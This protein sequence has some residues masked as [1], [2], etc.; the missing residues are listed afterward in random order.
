VRE[1][2]KGAGDRPGLSRERLVAAALE[3]VSAN[4]LDGL[5]MR[6]LADRLRVK[7]ASLYWHV[8]DRR[9]LLELLA[10]SILAGV[11]GVDDRAGWRSGV[12]AQS[13]A[14]RQVVSAQKDASRILLEVPDAVD[15]SPVLARMA[16]TLGAAGLGPAEAREVARMVMV[17]VIAVATT[18]ET[19]EAADVRGTSVAALAVDSGS[20]GVVVRRGE[21]LEGL[22]RVARDRAGAAPAVVRGETVIVR[23]LRGVGQ[24]EIELNGRRP[25]TFQVQG[26]TWNTTLELAGLDVRGIKLDSG[27]AKVEC[28]LP[29]PHGIVPI[30]V[31]GGVAGVRIHR[32]GGAAVVATVS[33]GVVRVNLDGDSHRAVVSD[34]RWSSEGAAEARDRYELRIAGG[35]MQVTL[36]SASRASGDVPVEPPAPRGDERPALDILLDGVA[37]RV[38]R[39]S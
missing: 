24:G 35:A 27:A 7:A 34:L 32:P 15:R 39:P 18:A 16:G 2:G 4:G 33:S 25:W 31:S 3:V 22:F 9:D 19:G 12:T 11:P 37:N 5:T 8:R 6:S 38:G 13:V 14:L 36:D 1:T 30:V 28:F 23:R 20:R 10:D 29:R 21:A 17:H 26:P